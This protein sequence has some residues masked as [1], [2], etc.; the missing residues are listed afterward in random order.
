MIGKVELALNV[1]S[2]PD[3]LR[4]LNERVPGGRQGFWYHGTF[5]T[6]GHSICI[7]ST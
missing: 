1:W 4:G 7:A 6:S 5:G 2:L 3:R